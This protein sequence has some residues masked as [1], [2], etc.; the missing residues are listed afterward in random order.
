[1]HQQPSE[2][3]EGITCIDEQSTKAEFKVPTEKKDIILKI[4]LDSQ[5][6]DMCLCQKEVPWIYPMMFTYNPFSGCFYIISD[7]EKQHTEILK[8]G[9]KISASVIQIGQ[10][11][12][13]EI[14]SD[15]WGVRFDA[16]VERVF[17]VDEIELCFD[18]FE[19]KYAEKVMIDKVPLK[20][21]LISLAGK[22]S[23]FKL[24]PTKFITQDERGYRFGEKCGTVEI[25]AQKFP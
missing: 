4:L 14:E 1:M 22:K 16:D 24:K 18:L 11:L 7:N 3:S 13:H 23:I 25:S 12:G 21:S 2:K 17:D 15:L 19:E 8:R 5:F 9:P 20:E 10:A 6:M